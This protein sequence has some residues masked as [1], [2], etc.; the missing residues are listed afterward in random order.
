MA[1]NFRIMA[2]V[3][4]TLIGRAS[5]SVGNVVFLT[6]KLLNVTR[7]KPVSVENPNTVPQQSYY[8]NKYGFAVSLYNAIRL[9]VDAG[10]K[11][12]A[13]KMTIQN[14]FLKQNLGKSINTAGTPAV[15][16]TPSKFVLSIGTMGVR[17]VIF[18][19][20]RPFTNY[21]AVS[22]IKSELPYLGALNDIAYLLVL[23]EATKEFAYTSQ[24]N[25]SEESLTATFSQNNISG[26]KIHIW[27]FFTSLDGS[28][29]SVPFYFSRNVSNF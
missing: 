19:E 20:A 13:V 3:Q 28:K 2:R 12:Q 21:V 6:W 17:R 5:G 10:L 7:S 1:Q 18:S 9:L 23:N 29:V 22:W 11:N 26:Q 24:S 8:R 14:Q 25:L 16:F 27:L 15:I 4:N